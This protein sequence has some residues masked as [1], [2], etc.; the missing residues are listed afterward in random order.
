MVMQQEQKKKQWRRK[1]DDFIES[2]RAAREYDVA[3]KT[4]T[5]Q[6][7][8]TSVLFSTSGPMVS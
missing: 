3:A 5:D 2:I 4:G 1:H 6:G 8:A 7:R